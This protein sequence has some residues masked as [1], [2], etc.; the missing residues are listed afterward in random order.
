MKFADHFLSK[1]SHHESGKNMMSSELVSMT[2]IRDTVPDLVPLPI[3][4]GAYAANSDIHFYLCSFH[5]MTN[6]IPEVQPLTAKIAELHK[7]SLSPNGKYGFSVPTYQSKWPQPV[8]WKDSWEEFFLL[9]LKWVLG[10]EEESQGYDAELGQLKEALFEKVVPRL[11]RPLETGGNHIEPRL[12]HGDLWDDNCSTDVAT[13]MPI[14]FDATSI[15]AHNEYELA[16]W[17]PPRH[18]IGKPYIKAYFRDFPVSAPESDFDDRLTLYCIRFDSL[19]SALYPGNLRFR[20]IIKEKIRFL[21]EKFPNGCEGT[22]SRKGSISY[23]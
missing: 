18:K 15:Y 5:D 8:E 16:P 9:S 10:K 17:R 4:W 20:N 6:D 19:S 12:V 21:V 14:I 2:L 23:T 3:S 22:H 1:V 11:L 7:K 13:N